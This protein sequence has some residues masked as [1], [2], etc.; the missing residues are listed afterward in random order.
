MG[1]EI[2]PTL[3]IWSISSLVAFRDLGS[4]DLTELLPGIFDSLPLLT[5]LY[6]ILV[7]IVFRSGISML[8]AGR[9]LDCLAYWAR[10]LKKTYENKMFCASWPGAWG[11]NSWTHLGFES[12]CCQLFDIHIYVSTFFFF[13]SQAAK[14]VG[15]REWADPESF[16]VSRA[17]ARHLFSF[18]FSFKTCI[19]FAFLGIAR[20]ILT[21]LLFFV[22]LYSSSWCMYDHDVPTVV[23]LHFDQSRNLN[24]NNLSNLPFDL[25][26]ENTALLEL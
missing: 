14:G 10:L 23:C 3:T 18:F 9:L 24:S 11:G 25:F 26:A 16:I 19:F 13:F 6:V 7:G 22:H 20:G 8:S 4:N 15:A 5:V 12:K 17:A 1:R 21:E 2:E